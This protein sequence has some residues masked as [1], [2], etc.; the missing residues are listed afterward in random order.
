[1][2]ASNV[3]ASSYGLAAAEALGLAAVSGP[4]GLIAMG[5][6]VVG[7]GFIVGEGIEKLLPKIR[8]FES[9]LEGVFGSYFFPRDPLILDLDG[10]GVSLTALATSNVFFD[11][12]NDGFREHTGWVSA[13]DGLVVRDL[14]GNGIIDNGSE[15]FGSQTQN[16]FAALS[17]LDS[18]ADGKISSLDSAFTSLRVWRDINQDGVS[19]T[20]E[21]STL[22]V[23]NVASI[24]LTASA[25]TTQRAGNAV[26][27]IGNYTQTNGAVRE[28]IAVGFTTDPLNSQIILPPNFTLSPDVLLLPNQRGYGKVPDLW[29][30]MTLDPVLKQMV[31]DF[32]VNLPTSLEGFVGT[33]GQRTVGTSTLY[34]YQAS[35]FDDIIS[36]WAGITPTVGNN[37]SYQMQLTVER[38]LDRTLPS[39]VRLTSEGAET[40]NLNLLNQFREFSTNLA[41]RFLTSATDSVENRVELTLLKDLIALTAGDPASLTQ[42]A[43]DQLFSTALNAPAPTLNPLQLH[44]GQSDYDFA[45]DSIVGDV[46]TFVD[47][48]LASLT[49]PSSTPY[50]NVFGWLNT[51]VRSELFEI[52]DPTGALLSN[53][54][55]ARTGNQSGDRNGPIY[56]DLIGNQTA[57]TLSGATTGV[58]GNQRII[59][60]GGNDTLAGGIGSDLYVFGNGFGNDTVRDASAPNVPNSIGDE[61]A[62][63]GTFTSNRALFSFAG[64][65]R[66]DLL[67]SFTGA[68]ETVTV[69]GYFGALDSGMFDSSGR[70][71]IER[72]S[73]ADGISF[74]QQQIRDTAMASLITSGD[75]TLQAFGLG[76]LVAGGLGNDTLLGRDGDDTLD[77]GIGNDTLSGSGGNDRLFGGDGNDIINGG[78]GSDVAD[79]GIGIDTVTFTNA[80]GAIYA[81]LL[82]NVG[83]ETALQVGTA[84]SE[85]AGISLDAI[86]NFETIIGSD[87]GDQLLG[88]GNDESLYGGGGNDLLIGEGGADTLTG[89][90]GSDRFFFTTAPD[91]SVDTINDFISGVDD[92]AINRAAFGIASGANTILA[93]DGNAG[94]AGSFLYNSATGMLSYD[95]DGAGGIAAVNFANIGIGIALTAND[96]V[97]YG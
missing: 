56:T 19:Q 73:F 85:T 43:V 2:I 70:A 30:A 66:T 62:F 39:F 71:S 61:I 51:G 65:S 26:E 79:G 52:I 93:V 24:N 28:A 94:S 7:S 36:R 27:F 84:N 15:L 18:N 54:V 16:G 25:S 89:G 77:G 12:N 13:G 1:M 82:L 46:Q 20:T 76:S 11:L 47:Q 91:G 49:V 87:Y 58:G 72:I 22:P 90:A 67:I 37:D 44:Y 69:L 5:I 38:F 29:V 21:L 14:N 95:S 59:G 31:V 97:L 32:M 6:F 81:D 53:N 60:L 63:Q 64:S 10:G 50:S 4:V 57:N 17:A 41:V 3:L 75:D 23:A 8:Q 45:T 74:S 33:F 80:N 55:R 68:T 40:N 35:A 86:F 88:S 83:R 92:L 48:E 34:R 9:W 78:L 42:S 96:L